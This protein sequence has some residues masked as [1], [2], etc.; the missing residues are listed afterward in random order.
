[1]KDTFHLK[2][3]RMIFIAAVL[4]FCAPAIAS[5]REE[6]V[7]KPNKEEAKVFAAIRSVLD[8]QVAAWNQGDLEGFMIGYW[9]SEAT[10]FIS[11]DSVTYG[12]Q[13]VFDRYKK[14]YETR[15]KMGTLEFSSLDFKVISKDAAVVHGTWQLT[16]ANDKPHG[17]FTLI[18][19]RT[20][21]GWRIVHD[22]TSSA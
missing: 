12:W 5:S 3:V 21:Q 1:M 13:T 17:R 9:R 6:H 7:V 22:H 8:A 15:E 14:G 11:G 18:F 2:L 19:R 20:S 4:Y 16:R 10:V